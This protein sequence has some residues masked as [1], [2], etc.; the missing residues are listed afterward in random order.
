MR[1]VAVF[2]ETEM[3]ITENECLTT[4]SNLIQRL[5]IPDLEAQV[6]QGEPAVFEF[7]TFADLGLTE[8]L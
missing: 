3:A 6:G 8:V 5:R 1:K 4:S 7:T 2:T